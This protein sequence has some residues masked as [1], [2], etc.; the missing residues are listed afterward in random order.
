[1]ATTYTNQN[2]NYPARFPRGGSEWL[3]VEEATREYDTVNDV[4]KGPK[5][6][7]GVKIANAV[8][9]FSD[10]FDEDATPAGI[11]TVRLNN[12]TT[13]VNLVTCTATQAGTANGFVQYLNEYAGLNH[14]VEDD[15]YWVEAI[16][17]TAPDNVKTAIL[18]FGVEITN[19]LWGNEQR[20]VES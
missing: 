2:F 1:M 5:I 20:T 9:A 11:C 16:F 19:N 14:L 15:G 7:K 8:L 4:V 6:A 17:T 13:Q 3:I 12:G 10:E 18:I